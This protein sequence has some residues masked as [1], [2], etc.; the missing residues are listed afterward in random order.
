MLAV[1]V[2]FYP[3]RGPVASSTHIELYT[4]SET[5]WP[6]ILA[7]NPHFGYEVRDVLGFYGLPHAEP[8]RRVWRLIVVVAHAPWN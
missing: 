8:A 5:R 7:R 3:F 1:Q 4:T 2:G 6:R